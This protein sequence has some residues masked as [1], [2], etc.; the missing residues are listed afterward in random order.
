MEKVQAEKAQ[1]EKA[2]SEVPLSFSLSL[3]SDLQRALRENIRQIESGL[4]VVDGGSEKQVR[5]GPT[6]RGRIDI[7]AKD[8]DGTLVVIELKAGQAEDPAVSQIASYMEALRKEYTS[9]PRIRGL[10]IAY[11]FSD[12]AVHASRLVPALTLRRYRFRFDFT[13]VKKGETFRR[14]RWVWVGVLFVVF[15]VIFLAVFSGV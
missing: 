11:D 5:F 10:L 7:L 3:E 1:V 13:T 14:G 8:Q 15:W 4:T 6:T 2:Q 12:R 9:S